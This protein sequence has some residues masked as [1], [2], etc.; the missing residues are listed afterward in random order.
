MKPC[1]SACL[2]KGGEYDNPL[3]RRFQPKEYESRFDPLFEAKYL[4]PHTCSEELG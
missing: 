1:L 2:G 3:D 4:N